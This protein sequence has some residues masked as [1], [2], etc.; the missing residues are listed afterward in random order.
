MKISAAVILHIVLEYSS[1]NSKRKNTIIEKVKG[2]S[3]RIWYTLSEI[4][5]GMWLKVLNSSSLV[6]QLIAFLRKLG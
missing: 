5:N 4:T 6:K 3:G 2:V 1:E